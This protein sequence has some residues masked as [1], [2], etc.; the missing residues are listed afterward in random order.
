MACKQWD[1]Y[2]YHVGTLKMGTRPSNYVYRKGRSCTRE[3]RV[4]CDDCLMGY[5]H[6]HHCRMSYYDVRRS[7]LYRRYPEVRE[8][9]P[10]GDYLYSNKK[11][12][13]R[14]TYLE[15]LEK[16]KKRKRRNRERIRKRR[17]REKLLIYFCTVGYECMKEMNKYP[18]K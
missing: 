4:V 18:I 3:I 6:W 16:E 2:E 12:Y 17:E 9:S 7:R 8:C 10:G 14:S 15:R 13:G 11:D 5:Y 1:D